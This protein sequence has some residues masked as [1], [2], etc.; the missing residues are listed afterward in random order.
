MRMFASPYVNPFPTSPFVNNFQVKKIESV[1]QPKGNFYLNYLAGRDGCAAYRRSFLE[2]YI[3]LTGVGDSV[4]LT[5]MVLNDGFYENIKTITLQRQASA[6]QKE[7]MSYLKNLQ[8]KFGFKLI[9][10]VDDV[11]FREE[12]PD[13]NASKYGFDD[14]ETRQNCIDM[15]NM[16]D[17]VTVTCKFMRDLYIDKTGK[18]D[19][20]V[21]PNFMPYSWI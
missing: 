4:S 6:H 18:K 8:S 15:I 1:E 14:E 10:E 13:Y 12:I 19:I 17:E 9:Y 21:V 16:V 7:F 3:N 5:K 20:T 11:V 2:N